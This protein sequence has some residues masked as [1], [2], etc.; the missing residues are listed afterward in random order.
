MFDSI[1]AKPEDGEEESK[2]G[3]KKKKQKKKVAFA[4]DQEK[5]IRVIKLK[6][7]GKKVVSSIIGFHAYG[8][9]LADTAKV[10]SRKLGTGAA[11]MMIEY[12]ELKVMGV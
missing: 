6:R 5:K 12:R 9:D 7:G 4:A 8:C 1:Y 11:A 2:E 3:S 10:L